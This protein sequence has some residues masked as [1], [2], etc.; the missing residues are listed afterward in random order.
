[1]IKIGYFA[2]GP[3]A[4]NALEKIINNSEIEISFI[5]VRYDSVDKKLGEYADK[6]NVPLLKHKNVNSREFIEKIKQYN[7]DLNVSMSFNQIFKTEIINLAPGKFINCHAGAL[8]FYRGRNILNWVLINGENKFGITVHYVDETIDTGDIIVQKFVPIERTDKYGDLLEKAYTYCAEAL[9]EALILIK[10]NKV[11]KI[12]QESIHPIGF[13]CSKR[14]IGDEIINW[15]W[16]SER[17]Y[18]FIRGI[19]IPG[20]GA[21]SSCNGIEYIINEAK[22]ID[23]APA[24]IDKTGNIVGKSKDGIIVKTGDTTILL[25]EIYDAYGKKEKDYSSFLIGRRFK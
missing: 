14:C 5:V 9:Y 4:H 2:D 20:P 10:N 23:N 7:V 12:K 16:S 3:W 15:N 1:M 8:P 19:A 22:L 25:T 13:Y 11:V 6:L 17:I 24:Y 18:N 21:R